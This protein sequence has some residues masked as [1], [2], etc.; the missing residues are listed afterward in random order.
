MI[1]FITCV[2][3]ARK[4][5][6]AGLVLLAMALAS[7]PVQAQLNLGTVAQR[8]EANE[9]DEARV[10]ALEELMA[11]QGYYRV[12][13]KL[14][15]A[16]FQGTPKT[17]SMPNLDPNTGTRRPP[18]FAPEGTTNVALNK[19]V[20]SSDAEPIVGELAMVTDGD[21]EAA[22]GSFVELGP[23]TQWVQIDLQQE[24][25]IYGLCVW[26]F[27]LEARAYRDVV[28]M[29]ADDPD[30]IENVRT[31]YNNDH[32]NSSGLGVGKDMAWIETNEGRLIQPKDAPVRARY[33]RLHSRGNTSN[34]L[35]HYIEVEVYGKAPAAD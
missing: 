24:Y 25:E 13:I 12:E 30:F 2:P 8:G 23:G 28:V 6:T 31:I 3:R 33:V 22:D 21:K 14:P 20:T 7:V 4:W 35:N 10:K 5:L 1:P 17:V 19:P 16:M 9:D 26:H 32:D 29:V 18:F 34:Q 11:A 27:H 15:T